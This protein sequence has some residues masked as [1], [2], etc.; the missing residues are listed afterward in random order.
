MR[1]DDAGL[2][3]SDGGQEY[4]VS[5]GAVAALRAPSRGAVY[6]RSLAVLS[7]AFLALFLG[8]SPVCAAIPADGSTVE[9]ATRL[10][11]SLFQLGIP[12]PL[13]LVAGYISIELKRQVQRRGYHGGD[14]REAFSDL[15]R[16]QRPSDGGA[17]EKAAGDGEAGG[18]RGR[19]GAGE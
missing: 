17:G 14:R 12:W 19:P 6:M 10:L 8:A 5:A 7:V 11:E 4:G 18:R 16:M 3:W 15:I 13:L 1:W 2:P 9:R